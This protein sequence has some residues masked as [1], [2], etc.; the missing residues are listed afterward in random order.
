MVIIC[1]DG[2]SLR[3]VI[4][5]RWRTGEGDS[6]FPHTGSQLWQTLISKLQTDRFIY[7]FFKILFTSQALKCKMYIG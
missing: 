2:L 3:D 7:L 6:A 4:A 1:G 5:A